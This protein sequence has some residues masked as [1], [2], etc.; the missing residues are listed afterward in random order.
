[1]WLFKLMLCTDFVCLTNSFLIELNSVSVSEGYLTGFKALMLS[2]VKTYC[3]F[4]QCREHAE[5]ENLR[6]EHIRML[7]DAKREKV[8]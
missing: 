8:P 4:S 5:L 3:S 6:G 7:E 2:I 1:M